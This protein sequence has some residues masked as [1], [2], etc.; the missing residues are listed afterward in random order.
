VTSAGYLDSTVTS[1]G[2]LDCNSAAPG[3]AE[4]ADYSCASGSVRFRGQGLGGCGEVAEDAAATSRI[5]GKP[6]TFPHFED[7]PYFSS[8]PSAIELRLTGPGAASARADW[9]QPA[10]ALIVILACL[11][12]LA[13]A[14]G[15]KELAKWG[16]RWGAP[17]TL[18]MMTR[19][20][21]I[22]R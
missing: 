3:A 6:P 9:Q 12:A 4:A 11:G 20:G 14:L 10:P 21:L 5:G 19:S 13:A 16:M 8:G 18:M 17:K 2:R 1:A 7:H 22:P 15:A